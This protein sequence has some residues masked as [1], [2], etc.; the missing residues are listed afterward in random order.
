[1]FFSYDD[2]LNAKYATHK[3]TKCAT[4]SK[5]KAAQSVSYSL[6]KRPIGGN[7]SM[8]TLLSPILYPDD[9]LAVS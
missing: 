4:S 9:Q 1:V 7:T 8:Y 5:L 6:P 2:I 3:K